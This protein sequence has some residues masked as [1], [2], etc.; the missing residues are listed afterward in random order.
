MLKA[1][2]YDFMHNDHHGYILTCPSNLGAT[3]GLRVRCA[4]R[5]WRC[6][7]CSGQFLSRYDRSVLR[8]FQDFLS[9]HSALLAVF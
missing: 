9:I 4:G 7:G 5:S 2:G 8:R 3:A 1:E 6:S